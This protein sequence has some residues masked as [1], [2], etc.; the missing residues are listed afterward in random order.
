MLIHIGPVIPLSGVP[1]RWVDYGGSL[2]IARSLWHNNHRDSSA[3]TLRAART[4]RVALFLGAALAFLWYNTPMITVVEKEGDRLRFVSDDPYFAVNTAPLNRISEDGYLLNAPSAR[5]TCELLSQMGYS[6]QLTEEAAEHMLSLISASYSP[7]G[8]VSP[9]LSLYAFQKNGV[10]FSQ[11]N[12]SVLYNWSTGTGKSVLGVVLA[13]DA[14]DAGRADRVIVFSP[15]H[16]LPEW[17]A[18]FAN[19]TSLTVGVVRS[20]MTP[21]KRKDFYESDQSQVWI[22]GHEKV[23]TN[24][25]DLIVKALRGKRCVVIYDE[26]QKLRNRRSAIHKQTAK[27]LKALGKPPVYALTATPVEKSPD[28]FYNLWRILDSSIFGLVKDFERDFTYMDGAKDAWGRYIGYQ[29]IQEMRVRTSPFIHSVDKNDPEIAKFFPSKHEIKIQLELSDRDQRLYGRI[30]ALARDEFGR[31]GDHTVLLLALNALR[32]ICIMPEAQY[33]SLVSSDHP[34]SHKMAEVLEGVR[35]AA[36]SKVDALIQLF[37][38]IVEAGEKVIVFC[39]LTNNG[40]IPLAEHL[41]RFQPLLYHGGM[42]A[43]A[44]E[45]VIESFKNDPGRQVLLMSDAGKEGLNLKVARYVIH[46]DTP[47]LWTHYVQRSD[48]VHRID[49]AEDSVTIYRFET[50]GTVEERI[51]QT[52]SERRQMS[53]TLGL[54]GEFEDGAEV[55]AQEDLEYLLFG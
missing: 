33:A 47:F 53:A 54:G 32:G 8:S 46:F 38:E 17:S 12:H 5:A 24:D 28:D 9:D 49:S 50:L 51:E 29:N 34:F 40:L 11:K 31:T 37:D 2:P 55:V 36:T 15:R 18:R 22:I 10:L 41:G 21:A 20:G 44:Q 45:L 16:L 35:P 3:V 30:V 25:Y 4:T 1:I 19:F 43:A 42:T 13:A 27:L 14:I 23:R 7:S 26:I 6:V 52:M 48:R 39:R